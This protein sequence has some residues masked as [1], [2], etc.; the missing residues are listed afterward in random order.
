[1]IRRVVGAVAVVLSFAAPGVW[2]ATWCHLLLKALK[3]GLLF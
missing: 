3:A 1:M 2:I